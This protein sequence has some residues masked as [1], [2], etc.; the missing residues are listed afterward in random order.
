MKQHSDSECGFF[1]ERG[2]KFPPKKSGAVYLS[3]L[4][5]RLLLL[6]ERNPA[7]WKKFMETDSRGKVKR[8]TNHPR[9]MQREEEIVIENLTEYYGSGEKLSETCVRED[10]HDII[11]RVSA[12]SFIVTRQEEHRREKTYYR[13][14]YLKVNNMSHGCIPN[15][16]WAVSHSPNFEMCVRTSVPVEKD[17]PIQLLF[18]EQWSFMGTYQRQLTISDNNG[19]CDCK[20]CTDKTECGTYVSALKCTAPT[21]STGHLLPENPSDLNAEAVW[22]CAGSST[23][24]GCSHTEEQE[25]IMSILHHCAID[26]EKVLA[27][28]QPHSQHPDKELSG[29]NI[30][31]KLRQ[32]EELHDRLCETRLHPQHFLIRAL[33]IKSLTLAS[34]CLQELN[35]PQLDRCIGDCERLLNVSTVLAP[36]DSPPSGNA[37]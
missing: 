19:P 5:L 22:K 21:C 26:M 1:S 17:A 15:A 7:Q 31:E 27:S 4:I 25:K 32:L 13:G 14:V 24:H 12:L 23:D 2:V 16:V 35:F 28:I 11:S 20:R 29:S 3:I 8:W 37:N 18:D 36:G 30:L 34:Q 10:L 33:Q 6:K 9:K